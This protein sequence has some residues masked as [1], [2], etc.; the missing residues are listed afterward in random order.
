VAVV[1]GSGFSFLGEVVRQGATLFITADVRYHE[2]QEAA[3]KGIDLVILDHFATERPVLEVVRT[4][5]ERDL[6][7][8]PVRVASSSSTP[9]VSV[10]P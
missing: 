7:G 4:R 1:G 10:E 6:P 3:A 5:L 9:Y 2:A 8:V